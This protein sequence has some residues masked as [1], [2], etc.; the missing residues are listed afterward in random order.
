MLQYIKE[1]D[2]WQWSIDCLELLENETAEDL[3]NSIMG[4]DDVLVNTL[5][6][7]ELLVN[8]YD[9]LKGKLFFNFFKQIHTFKQIFSTTF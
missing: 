2:T 6:L 5:L 4:G 3:A 1:Y 7:L 9:H 8:H